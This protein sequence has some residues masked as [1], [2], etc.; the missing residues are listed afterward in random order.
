MLCRWCAPRERCCTVADRL[1]RRKGASWAR[2]ENSTLMR[3]QPAWSL[4]ERR[5]HI[6]SRRFLNLALQ[7][8]QHDYIEHKG[9][10]PHHRGL[11]GHWRRLRR[12]TGEARLRPH[13][14]CSRWVTSRT[15]H[16]QTEAR[17]RSYRH[18]AH[19]ASEQKGWAGQG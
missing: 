11:T 6:L 9:N 8:K 4:S 7:G 16:S 17:N 12:P 3:P 5:R 13:L 1:R 14:G 2:T 18:S 19:G 10:R 15:T